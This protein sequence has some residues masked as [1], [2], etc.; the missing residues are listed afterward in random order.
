MK[1][2][3]P[4][5]L[6]ENKNKNKKSRPEGQ[7]QPLTFCI[8]TVPAVPVNYS[9]YGDCPSGAYVLQCT[10]TVPAVPINYT[11]YCDLAGDA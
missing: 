3:N 6:F 10:V 7:T 1:K 5:F 11:L 2:K 9:L 8:V 4:C